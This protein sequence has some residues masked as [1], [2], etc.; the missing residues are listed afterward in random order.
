MCLFADIPGSR[1]RENDYGFS[2]VLHPS[3]GRMSVV[4]RTPQIEGK[5]S[6]I[7]LYARA[8]NFLIFLVL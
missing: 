8:H 4:R 6:I 2:G 7:Y 5:L 3:Q 1:I